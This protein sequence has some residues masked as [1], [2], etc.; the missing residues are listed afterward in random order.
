MEQEPGC[1]LTSTTHI[2]VYTHRSQLII[3]T[4]AYEQSTVPKSCL[5]CRLP[6][7]TG[8][9]GN[10]PEKS[11]MDTASQL[12]HNF[13]SKIFLIPCPTLLF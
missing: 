7:V 11:S 3:K 2:H 13:P 12:L 6:Y 8:Y 9:L 5:V 10:H 4:Q 1:P